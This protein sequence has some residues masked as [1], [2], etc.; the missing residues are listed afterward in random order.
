MRLITLAIHTYP[1]ALGISKMLTKAGIETTL[2]NVNLE[3]PVVSPGVR[4]RIHEHDLAAALRLL[5]DAFPLAA[6]DTAAETAGGRRV[7]VPTDFSPHSF[8]A[9]RFAMAVA[10][11][12]STAVLL[13]HA[14]IT[15][16]VLSP[17][18]LSEELNFDNYTNIVEEAQIDHEAERLMHAFGKRLTEAINDGTVPRALFEMKVCEGIPEEVIAVTAK[19]INPMLIVMGTRSALTKEREVIGSVTAEV[20]DTV[21]YPVL[22]IPDNST[23]SSPAD[24]KRILLFTAPDQSDII[25][26]DTLLDILPLGDGLEIVLANLPSRRK[27]R[28]G[29]G[30]IAQLCNYCTGHYPSLRFST[31]ALDPDTAADAIAAAGPDLLVIPSRRRNI[32]TRLFNPTLAHRLLFRADLPL[33]S[34]PV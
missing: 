29:A 17:T 6:D 25:A 13:L 3:H 2:Q 18:P 23:L 32:L 19:S 10:G 28:L 27:P 12:R 11:S 31:L 24:I 5:E 33:L 30:D 26:V 21:R 1:Y 20:L 4:I 15:P 8:A 34:V 14:F 16:S 22:S 7:L 9:C